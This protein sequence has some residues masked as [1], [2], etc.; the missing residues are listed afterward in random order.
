MCNNNKAVDGID[1]CVDGHEELAIIKQNRS[2]CYNCQYKTSETYADDHM[3]VEVE[4][5]GCKTEQ[6]M[7]L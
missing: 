6:K 3:D 5:K 4:V 1:C 2:K 7:N